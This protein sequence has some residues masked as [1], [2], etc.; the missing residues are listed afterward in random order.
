MFVVYSTQIDD[1]SGDSEPFGIIT[2]CHKLPPGTCGPMAAADV[3]AQ[4][5][6]EPLETS[7]DYRGPDRVVN[8]DDLEVSAQLGDDLGIPKTAQPL[9]FRLGTGAALQ[10]C[11]AEATST[12]VATCT[13]N[14]VTQPVA[15]SVPLTVDYAGNTVLQRSSITV[16]L[17]LQTPTTISFAGPAFIANGEP[18]TLT[19]VLTDFRDHP[20]QG[21]PVTLTMGA[22]ANAQTCTGTT[23]TTG[24]AACTVAVASQPLNTAAVFVGDSAYAS[25]DDAATVNLEYCTGRSF[26]L[27]ATID[28]VGLPVDLSAQPDTGSARTAA[29]T[30][31][32]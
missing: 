20:V 18:T 9:T 8:G 13:I 23:D 22:G 3:Q 28:L 1:R 14:E 4:C 25:S 19:A 27:E 15:A 32:S 21:A 29:A 6:T 26:G 10:T 11:E 5:G 17:A 31:T 24:T 2:A 12:G 7:T 16:D 30:A